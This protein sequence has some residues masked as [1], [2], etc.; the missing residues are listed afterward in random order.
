MDYLPLNQLA[1]VVPVLLRREILSTR[2]KKPFYTWRIETQGALYEA[3][4][5]GVLLEKD[6]QGDQLVSEEPVNHYMRSGKNRIGFQLCTR[7]PED[8]GGAKISLSLY[9]NEDDA[10]ESEK[11]LVGQVTFNAA[12]FSSETPEKAIQSSLLAVKLDSGNGYQASEQGDVIIHSAVI[13]S[14]KVR[15]HAFHI[16]QDIEVTVPFPEWGFLSADPIEFPDAFAEYKENMELYDKKLVTPLYDVHQNIF[17]IMQTEDMDKILPLF[18]ERNRELDLAFYYSPGTSE[19]KLKNSLLD[20]FDDEDIVFKLEEF[21][22]AKTIVS[23]NKL[24]IQ[25][26]ADAM[27][28]F[29]DEEDE[30]FELYPVWF[31]QKNGKWIICR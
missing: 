19:Q 14:S 17:E 18:E 16:Y 4:I 29:E 23:D 6:F 10:P 15:P 24:L 5:N 8:F 2:I 13:E 7:K 31:Y 28:Y 25:L 21:R 26:G 27:L 9:V 1:G 22:Y 3:K 20:D 12:D 11:A 30:I